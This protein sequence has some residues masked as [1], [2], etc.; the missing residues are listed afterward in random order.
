MHCFSMQVVMNMCF[1]LNP[2]KNLAQIRL[3]VSRKTQ[4]RTFNSQ[5]DVTEPKVK[6]LG[7]SNNQLKSCQQLK[8]QFQVFENHGL[9]K[10]E[11]T[12]N[13]LTV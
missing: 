8:G 7:Y 5:N 2:D 1:L 11:M 10:P 6:R 12:F 3:V 13:L 9:Q 4:K